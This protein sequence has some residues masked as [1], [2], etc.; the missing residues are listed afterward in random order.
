MEYLRLSLKAVLVCAALCGVAS[1]VEGP[2]RPLN[3]TNSSAGVFGVISR[4]MEGAGTGAIIGG[5]IGVA[6]QSGM[7]SS[8]DEAMKKKLLPLIP[9]PSCNHVLLDAFKARLQAD[10]T[11]V[12]EDTKSKKDSAVDIAIEECGLRLADA[13]TGEYASY[14][15]LAMSVKPASAAAWGEKIQISGRNRRVFD[16]FVNQPGLAQSE[17]EDVLKRAGL[18]AADKIIY[19]N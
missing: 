6:I 10:G 15:N 5:L 13:S 12:V 1:A 14:V 11:F 7:Q 2:G 17:L 3:V 9:D 16:D 4:R 18:R 19:K 8:A